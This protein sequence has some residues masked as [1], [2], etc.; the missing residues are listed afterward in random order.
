MES[1]LTTVDRVAILTWR[2][3]RGDRLTVA[4]AAELIEATESGT[5]RLLLRISLHTPIFCDD[6]H[7]WCKCEG[8]R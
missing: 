8:A 5:R 1:E 6:E 2:L 4:Q 7:C 3:S